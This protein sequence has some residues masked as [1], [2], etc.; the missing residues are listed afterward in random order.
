MAWHPQSDSTLAVTVRDGLL[1]VD[2]KAL[3][4]AGSTE[5]VCDQS[6]LP[7][8]LRHLHIAS[9][10]QPSTLDFSPDGHLLAAGAPEGKVMHA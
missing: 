4:E 2:L 7:S 5:V 8:G 3:Q 6:T 9:D 10:L 1:V